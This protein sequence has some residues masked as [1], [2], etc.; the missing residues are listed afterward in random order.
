MERRRISQILHDELQQRIFAVKLQVSTFYDAYQK[1][2]M[3][4]A[5]A[6]FAQLQEGL[7]DSINMTRNLSIDLSPAILQG[8]G[9][10]DALVWLSAQMKEQYGLNV[11]IHSN[12]IVG[13]FED[14]LRILLFQAVREILFNIV[15]H[16]DT[17]EVNIGMEHINGHLR[18]TIHDGGKGFDPQVVLKS[19]RSGGLVKLQQRLNLVGCS[20]QIKSQPNGKGTE[21]IIEIPLEK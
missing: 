12:G 10:T 1:G 17:L 15:K 9:L 11:T 14:T 16:A 4:S 21:A 13:R 3:R 6:D 7:D 2:D 5:A 19:S 20:L 8:D 18:I